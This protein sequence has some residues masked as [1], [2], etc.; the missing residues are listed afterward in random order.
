MGYKV[1]L[2]E[3][4]S[5][6]RG[7]SI[8]RARMLDRGDYLYIHYGD[9]YKGFDVRIDVENPQK[10]IPYIA[11]SE[12]IR[13][14]QRLSDQDIVYVL[15]SETVEDLGHA[16]LFNNPRKLP[17]VAGT[18]TTIVHV[19]RPDLVLPSY[20]NWLFQSSRFK[21]LL[22]QYVKGMKVFRVHPDDLARIEI[23][24]PSIDDQRRIVS[25]LD[26]IFERSLINSQI[27]GYLAALLDAS[28]SLAT[29]NGAE[30]KTLPEVVDIFSGG[31]PKT[32]NPEYWEGG[33]IPFFAP[34][35]VTRSVYALT[36][37]KHITEMGLA[38]CNSSLYPI[39]S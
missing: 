36:T 29:E 39:V 18:E 3:I 34:G 19:N 23:E 7:A 21:R 14:G 9:L 8:P 28:Y 2:G 4:C 20:L 5:F 13:E 38:N 25:I 22:R 31:T 37:E 26:A 17:A 1:A 15:T 35:D 11:D 10:P 16:F 30:V 33:N 27:N 12:P 32:G 6:S 24:I